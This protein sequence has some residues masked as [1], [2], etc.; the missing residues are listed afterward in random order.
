MSVVH[1]SPSSQFS[2]QELGGSHVSPV[3]IELFPQLAEQSESL[4]ALQ[5]SGQHP[6]LA[7]HWVIGV[8]THSALQDAASPTSIGFRQGSAA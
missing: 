7:M 8:L 6:S 3:S 5:P 4:V 1:G 2:S